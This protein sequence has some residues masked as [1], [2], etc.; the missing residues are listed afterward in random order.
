MFDAINSQAIKPWSL[1]PFQIRQALK[2]RHLDDGR[3]GVRHGRLLATL[4]FGDGAGQPPNDAEQGPRH[5]R[6]ANLFSDETA[7]LVELLRRYQ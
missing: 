5:L 1:Q 7:V 3:G 6:T 2:T 4:Q